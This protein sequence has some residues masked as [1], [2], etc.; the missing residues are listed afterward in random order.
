M[1][2]ATANI[3]RAISGSG[4]WTDERLAKIPEYKAQVVELL[5][6]EFFLGEIAQIIGVTAI[7]IRRWRA[8]DPEFEEACV[9]AESYVTDTLEKAAIHRARDGVKE[10]VISKGQLVYVENP[11]TGEKEILMTRKYSDG[12]AQFLLKGRRR[13]VYGDRL[14]TSNTHQFDVVG[15]KETL[16]QKLAAAVAGRKPAQEERES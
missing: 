14:E 2:E 10:P 15:M 16:Q 8:Q 9:D 12:L 6:Q 13:E 4:G 11:E 3:N 7:T 5:R 1:S